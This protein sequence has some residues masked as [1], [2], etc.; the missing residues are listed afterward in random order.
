MKEIDPR[1]YCKQNLEIAD[2]RE[3][4]FWQHKI[5]YMI[6]S[7]KPDRFDNSISETF[8]K[9]RDEIIENYAEGL[10]YV[11]SMALQDMM[12]SIIESYGYD[13]EPVENPETF[14]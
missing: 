14:F 1:I 12:I 13:V 11:V 10:K 9:I 2:L 7:A 8:D 6:E 3:L 4:E 5:T